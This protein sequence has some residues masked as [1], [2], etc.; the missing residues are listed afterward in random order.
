[1]THT[2]TRS[3]I[4]FAVVVLGI[5]VAT[6][7]TALDYPRLA[8]YMPIGVA[9]A[10]LVLAV[11]VIL[12]EAVKSRLHA[13]GDGPSISPDLMDMVTAPEDEVPFRQSLVYFIWW[14]GYAVAM[15]LVGTLVASAVFLAVFLRLEA[16]ASMARVAV[17]VS[18][19]IAVLLILQYTVGLRLPPSLLLP[20][21]LEETG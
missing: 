17:S 6:I 14:V 13:D 16:K 3:R 15:A 10:G 21:S 4:I 11:V 2:L 12:S 7:F 5:C 19:A 18:I 20:V 1:M 9:V 8:R